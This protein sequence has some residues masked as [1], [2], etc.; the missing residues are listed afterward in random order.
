MEFSKQVHFYTQVGINLTAF[1]TFK[2]QYSMH[3]FTE[4]PFK[5]LVLLLLHAL[6]NTVYCLVVFLDFVFYYCQHH[7]VRQK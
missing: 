1:F 3:L 7:L 2:Q 6:K 4:Y 5:P